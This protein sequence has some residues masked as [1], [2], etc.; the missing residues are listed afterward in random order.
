MLRKMIKIDREKCNGCGACENVCESMTAGSI[1]PG[2]TDRAIVVV[3]LD[4]W[5]A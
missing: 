3:P 1:A 2:A 5:E 4:E